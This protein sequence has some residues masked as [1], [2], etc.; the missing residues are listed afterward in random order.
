MIQY[1]D[2]L[3][4]EGK[5]L[6]AEEIMDKLEEIKVQEYNEERNRV[7]TQNDIEMGE[8]MSDRE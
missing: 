4:K 2:T 6:E 8:L 5:L 7:L 1:R 3:V